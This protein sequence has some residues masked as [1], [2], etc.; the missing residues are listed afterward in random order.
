MGWKKSNMYVPPSSSSEGLE[1]RGSCAA[2]PYSP[3]EAIRRE[4]RC[5]SRPVI[6]LKL[7]RS[8]RNGHRARPR[9]GSAF[10]LGVSGT[11]RREIRFPGIGRYYEA[12]VDGR[13]AP[14]QARDFSPEAQ[15]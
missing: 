9:N 14:G 2:H 4:L 11:G 6:Y 15:G 13:E 3:E 10:E 1:G 12:G 7:E 8:G 5:R